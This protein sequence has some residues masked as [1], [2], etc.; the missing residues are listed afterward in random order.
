MKSK[1]VSI[2]AI[3]AG[4]IAIVLSVGAYFEFADIFAMIIASVFVVL[5]L[6]YRSYKGAILSY[7]VGGIIAI[8]ISGFN[9]YSLVFPVYFTFFGIYPVLRDYFSSKKVKNYLILIIG[10]VWCVAVSYGA[11][12]Y[13]LAMIGDITSG[14]PQWFI[15][16]ALYFIVVI[17]LVFYFVFDR[18]TVLVQR[19]VYY[20]LNKIVK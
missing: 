18:F 4:L 9:I 13:Y 5:P 7:L 3:S 17:A 8:I 20:Y 19:V 14:L 10:A 12:F 2:S 15:E 11:Y 1:I 6:Y 16:N